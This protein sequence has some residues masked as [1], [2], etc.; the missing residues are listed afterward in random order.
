MTELPTHYRSA[1]KGLVEIATMS[2]RHLVNSWQ[3]LV[4]TDDGSRTDEIAAMAAQIVTNNEA[5]AEAEVAKAQM[6]GRS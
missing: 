4:D 3:K 1:S 2:H 5:H 6:E